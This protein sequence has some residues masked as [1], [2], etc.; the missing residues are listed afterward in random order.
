MKKLVT[1]C[2]AFIVIASIVPGC[3][4]VVKEGVGV[5]LGAKGVSLPTQDVGSL[6]GYNSFE[7]GS[8]TDSFGKTPRQ[9]V[10]YLPAALDTALLDKRIPN[11]RGGKT[12]LIKGTFLHYETAGMTGQAFGP[13][14]EVVAQVKLI[15]KASGRVLG[16]SNC[17]GRTKE[18]VNM[19]VQKKAEGLAN[20][21]VKWIDSKYPEQGRLPKE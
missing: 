12:L 1:F 4:R 18:S 15:D 16:V 20:A 19:G 6:A 21:I 13:L 5:A 8:F 10:D 17:V 2:V 7:I 14:E 3:S 9:V 11:T